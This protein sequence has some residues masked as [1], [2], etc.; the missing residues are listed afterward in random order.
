MKNNILLT[1]MFVF[2]LVGMVGFSSALDSSFYIS[3]TTNYSIKYGCSLDGNICGPSVSCFMTIRYPNGTLLVNNG[4]AENLNNGYFQYNLTDSQTNLSGEY[5]GIVRC[6]NR[7]LSDTQTFMYEVN[8]G[9]IRPSES[10]T[11]AITRSIWF[12]YFLGILGIVGGYASRRKQPV[13]WSLY[14]LGFLLILAGLNILFVGLQDEIV[15]ASLESFFDSFTAISF[16]L[17]WGGFMFIAVIWIITFIQTLI[18]RKK[19]KKWISFGGNY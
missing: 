2:L 13:S 8:P 18:T 6:T 15:N 5:Q 4:S 16:I 10:R 14:I 12:L 17:Y 1:L 3:K 19:E 7:T 9:G 11:N